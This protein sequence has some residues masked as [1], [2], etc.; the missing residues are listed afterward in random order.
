A[1]AYT[2][3]LEPHN[4]PWLFA[5]EWPVSL[6]PE[7]FATYDFQLHGKKPVRERIRYALASQPE[8][9]LPR[10]DRA[11]LAEALELPERFNPRTV[12]LGRRLRAE[13]ANAEEIVARALG[14]L[15]AQGLV[16]TLQ[17]P[18]MGEHVADEFLFDAR[19]GFCEHFAASFVVLMRAAG[20]PARVVT[21]YQGGEHNPVDDTWVIRQSDAH[22]WAEVWLE[23]TG[24]RRVDP[25]AAAHPARI[26]HNLAAALPAGE[27]LPLLR[28]LDLDLLRTLRYRWWALH[29]A[30]NQWVLGYDPERQ[31]DLLRR[32]GMSSPDWQQMTAWLAGLSGITLLL[33]AAALLKRSPHRDPLSRAWARLSRRLGKK[34]LARQSWE[35]P[36]DYAA[37]VGHQLPARA[38]EIRAIAELYSALRYGGADAKLVRELS[39]R[40]AAFKP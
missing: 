10:Q 23:G 9:I 1:Y 27:P 32:L 7:A 5:L 13:S 16:Y 20:V 37:R 18:L 29:H 6:P 39:R 33:L 2:V 38:G 25:T 15:R 3:T 21:G 8:A 17:P 36:H 31:R 30:W 11:I 22:A 28:R 26:E 19:R 14:F 24:W 12:A 40:I 35:G 34:G 4:Q